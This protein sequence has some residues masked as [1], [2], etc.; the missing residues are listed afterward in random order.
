MDLYAQKN[1]NRWVTA[2]LFVGVGLVV[3]ALGAGLAYVFGARDPFMLV[4]V[5]LVIA[6][7]LM[8]ITWKIADRAVLRAAGAREPNPNVQEEARLSDII[9]G[10][11]LAAGITTPQV[12]VIDDD[13][14]NAFAVGRSPDSGKVAF[15]TGLLHTLTRSEVEAVAAHEVSHIT[16]RDSLIGVYTA[17]LLGFA[18]IAARV[19]FRGALFSGMMGGRRRGGGGQMIVLLLAVLVAVLAAGAAFVLQRAVSRRRE[20]RADLSSASLTNNPQAMISALEKID[21]HHSPIDV[22]HGAASH[23]WIEEPGERDEEQQSFLDRLT[24]T[25]PPIEER[26]ARLREVAGESRG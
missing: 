16:G 22:G 15:T 20:T 21:K 7:I 26:I 23:L 9:E 11:A 6:A 25:H 19:M 3:L 17:V 18:I 24:N 10:V 2:A 13:S 4:G 5:G 8:A 12:F 1:R 14:L